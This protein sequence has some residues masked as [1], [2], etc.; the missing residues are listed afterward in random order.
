MDNNISDEDYQHAQNIWNKFEIKNLSEYSD[1]YL[2]TDVLL[3][4][5]WVDTNIDVLNISDESDQGY[6]LE[7]DLEYPNHLHAHKD[8]PLCPEHRIPPNSKLSKLMTTLYNKERYVIHY[9]NLKQALELGLK[10]TKTHRILQFKQSPWLKGYI[11]LNT[12]LCTI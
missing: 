12:K 5:D 2:K 1:L 8:F 9:R 6:I 4:A 7:V 11:D 3:L 10:I